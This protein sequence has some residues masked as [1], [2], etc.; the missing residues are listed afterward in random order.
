MFCYEVSYNM[1][2]CILIKDL[3]FEAIIGILPEE[4]EKVQKV[5]LSAEIKYHYRDSNTYIDYAEIA[6]MIKLRVQTKCYGLLEEAL[7][8]VAASCFNHFQ[9][10]TSLTLYIEKPDILK[11]CRVGMKAKF[12]RNDCIMIKQ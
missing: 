1:K 9:E 5:K 11:S 12:K 2:M 3:N 7:H 8:D 4:R 6:D 10:I